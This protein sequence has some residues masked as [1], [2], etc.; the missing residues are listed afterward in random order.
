MHTFLEWL[1]ASPAFLLTT[2]VILAVGFLSYCGM[3]VIVPSIPLAIGAFVLAGLVEGEVFK[4]NITK[5]IENLQFL[6]REGLSILIL[7]TLDGQLHI[8]GALDHPILQA[9]QKQKKILVHLNH[10]KLNAEE[11]KQKKL[12]EERLRIFQKELVGLIV[13]SK[14][15]NDHPVLSATRQVLPKLKRKLLWIRLSVPVSIIGGI[16]FGF[17]TASALDI[18]LTGLGVS[19]ALSPLIWPLAVVACIGYT[20]LLYHTI[21]NMI[22]HDTFKQWREWAITLFKRKKINGTLENNW[23]YGLRL[24]GIGL[25]IGA[26][27]GVGVLATLATAGTWWLAVKEGISLLPHLAAAAGIIRSIIVPVAG[28]AILIFTI[29]NSLTSVM[30]MIA[31][32]EHA[33]PMQWIKEKIHHFLERKPGETRWHKWNPFR[34]LIEA[35]T[36]PIKY[37]IFLGHLIATGLMWDR[38][39]GLN[40][41]ATIASG[42]VGAASD[43][44]VDYHYVAPPKQAADTE[45]HEEEQE[46]L[47]EKCDEHDHHHPHDDDDSATCEHE[48][49]DAH[50]HH[51]DVLID[52]FLFG[53]F[54][55][56]H[57]LSQLW[58]WTGERLWPTPSSPP[59][60]SPSKCSSTAEILSERKLEPTHDSPSPHPSPRALQNSAGRGGQ[61]RKLFSSLANTAL[62]E[63]AHHNRE[64]NQAQE[65]G[66]LR[67]IGYI[68]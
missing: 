38:T 47:L 66:G 62:G 18:A 61:M 50:D 13:K 33:R 29:V 15:D 22:Q 20:L 9:Y 23:R 3:L 5:G 52:W 25:F 46:A 58:D 56:L 57:L 65:A 48:H 68:L 54:S 60:P 63:G 17:A 8:H 6:G 12:A 10:K 67:A 43:G 64:P 49:D 24:L 34:L 1:R 37:A 51:H 31:A 35:I 26:A 39:P 28:T 21:S 7:Q 53:L 19:V 44:L 16:G 11:R 27:V 41:A 42:V 36:E 4:Q 30:Q 45:A 40:R 2:G 14:N 55:P 32:L 59:S